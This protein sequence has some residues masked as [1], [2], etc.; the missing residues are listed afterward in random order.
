[1]TGTGVGLQTELP[2]Y[3][4]RLR[5]DVGYPIGPKPSGGTISGDRS[6]IF[7]L[8]AMTRF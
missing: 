3:S 2:Y 5:A 7:Y 4:I 8:Q 1:L 6:P